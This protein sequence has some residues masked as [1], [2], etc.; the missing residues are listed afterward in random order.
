MSSFSSVKIGFSE[1]PNKTEPKSPRWAMTEIRDLLVALASGSNASY[2]FSATGGQLVRSN[3]Y[4][5]NSSERIYQD[6]YYL[7]VPV[8][9][10]EW[11]SEIFKKYN[12][13]FQRLGNWKPNCSCVI[14]LSGPRKLYLWRSKGSSTV[15]HWVVMV[16]SSHLHIMFRFGFRGNRHDM[17]FSAKNEASTQPFKMIPTECTKMA[18]S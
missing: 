3:W 5:P 16:T 17:A 11:H 9:I 7:I 10:F 18:S 1:K 12:R 13:E 6:I 14:S 4:A 15:N 2:S 8:T